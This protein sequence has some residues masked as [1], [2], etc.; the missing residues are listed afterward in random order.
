M[1]AATTSNR[2]KGKL[3][4]GHS[5][6]QQ[7][8]AH[9]QS[10]REVIQEYCPLAESLE[11]ELGQQYFRERGNKAFISDTIPVP[12]L[13]NNDGTL[14]R[15][16]AEVF[17]TSCVEAE[18]KGDLEQDI[19]VLEIGIGVGLFARFFL[20]NFRDLCLENK[21]DYYDR[22]CYIA[23]DRSERMLHDMLRHGVLA[24]HP[25][26]YRVRVID[27]LEPDKLLPGDAMFLGRTSKPLRAVF[28]N[29]LLDCLPAAILEKNGD[30]LK[31]LCVRTCIARSIKLAEH[32]DMS[33]A[34][35]RERAKSNDPLGREELME[36][37]GMFASEYDYR[38]TSPKQIPYGEFATEF[39]RTRAKR[40]MHNYGAIQCL[41]RLLGLVH[42]NGFVLMNEYG[43]TT[44]NRD[45]EYEHQRFSLAT[46]VGLNFPLLKSYF[47]D[48]R[49]LTWVEPF[50]G[51]GRG[52]ET[53]LLSHQ[54]ANET[55]VK[56]HERF[57]PDAFKQ[58]NEPIE[59]ARACLKAGRFEM[60]ADFYQ[61][62]LDKQPHNWYLMGEIS[63]F[64]TFQMRDS[65]AGI[66][67]A[68]LALAENPACSAELWN[69]LGDGLYE[70]G[71]TAEAKSAYQKALA[72]NSGDVRAR[73][74]LAWVHTRE[75]D[76]TAA[77]QMIAEALA[78]DKT[79]QLRDRL[80]QKQQEIL[81]LQAIQHQQ[82]YLLYVNFVSRD[83]KKQ[84]D[85]KA[86]EPQP[87][88]V[89]PPKPN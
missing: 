59:H 60:A 42:P 37:Y 7:V 88:T 45:D 38:P 74:N 30:Q 19:F 69:I 76:Y 11:W 12:F 58:L 65:K 17:F 77:L 62:A 61:K 87:I 47:H 79:G 28:L 55:V 75:K 1:A 53:R 54:P 89:I 71:R 31:Q 80:L 8:L 46:A 82:E 83:A 36:I 67:M 57:H 24:S 9:A 78:Y 63:S 39:L 34:S 20:D 85:D 86:D 40:I 43:M 73:H 56:F 49:K 64:L 50:S 21:K 22:L 10:S 29:Y 26:R 25:G 66:D 41:E 84:G 5:P 2:D 13:I 68:K 16:A 44:M 23:A 35:L 32:T 70:F 27:A 6:C 33:L 52:I 18:K 51:E 72:V 81:A 48:N 3:A 4:S 14:S 15:N